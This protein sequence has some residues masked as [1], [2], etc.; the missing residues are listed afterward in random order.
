MTKANYTSFVR[1]DRPWPAHS[2]L[3]VYCRFV[4]NTLLRTPHHAMIV[5]T[6]GALENRL[7]PGSL[8]KLRSDR[9]FETEVFF[10]REEN[11]EWVADVNHVVTSVPFPRFEAP[12][13][14]TH[15]HETH[16]QMV[17]L[18]RDTIVRMENQTPYKLS[19]GR[20]H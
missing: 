8:L 15:A 20:L 18:V 9:L 11:G 14:E 12:K 19:R 17:A 13:D 16:E 3:G 10:A 5:S 4:R 2:L 1:E 6:I 7:S